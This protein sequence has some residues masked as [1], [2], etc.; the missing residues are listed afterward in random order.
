MPDDELDSLDSDALAIAQILRHVPD[1]AFRSR[2]RHD[3][4][5]T[6]DMTRT[7][8]ALDHRLSGISY[9]HIPA[10]DPQR[11][12]AFYHEVF[13][14]E[15]RGDPASPSFT[16][17]T[18]HV[19]GAWH[20]DLPPAPEGGVLPYIYVDD[21]DVTLAKVASN[22]CDI[23]TEPFPEGPLWVAT[24]HDPAGNV[25]GVY[26]HGPRRERTPSSR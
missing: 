5:R 19:T 15:L 6:F 12:G 11:S 9:L 21:V 4:E 22:G 1:D 17:G 7:T 14:W 8:E 16:D 23:K 3:L 24:F 18:G 13:G 25:V 20:A 10:T 26:Q 2:L